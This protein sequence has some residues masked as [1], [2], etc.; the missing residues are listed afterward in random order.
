MDDD[1]LPKKKKKK[2]VL[3]HPSK[4]FRS[5]RTPINERQAILQETEALKKHKVLRRSWRACYD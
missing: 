4:G 1:E 5:L 2:I 3:K